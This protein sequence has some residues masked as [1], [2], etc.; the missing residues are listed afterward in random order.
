LSDT[1]ARLPEF[2]PNNYLSLPDYHVAAKT[3]T[4]DNKRDNWTFGYTPSYVVGVWVGNNDNTPMNPYLASGLSGAAPMWNR[5][6]A[7]TLQ[8]KADEVPTMPDGVFV[9]TD[10][11]CGASEYFIK[12]TTVPA[13]LCGEKEKPTPS[14]ISSKSEKKKH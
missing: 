8:G 13:S 10:F 14:P 6:F 5:I 7:T 9:K 1:N 2:G 11:A 3:G 4:T 12:G